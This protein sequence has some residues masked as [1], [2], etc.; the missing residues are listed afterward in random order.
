MLS[1]VTNSLTSSPPAEDVVHLCLQVRAISFAYKFHLFLLERRSATGRMTQ[2]AGRPQQ[3]PAAARWEAPPPASIGFHHDIYSPTSIP[4]VQLSEISAP[5]P[6]TPTTTS[7]TAS[8]RI[9]V[10]THPICDDTV[11]LT[12]HEEHIASYLH[13]T[14]PL[15]PDVSL[16]STN[17]ITPEN[18]QSHEDFQIHHQTEPNRQNV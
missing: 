13:K 18:P 4:K 7:T 6:I 2:A 5:S 8:T 14:S 11:L 17:V 15:E 9:L 1:H 12:R 3:R 16:A 10:H